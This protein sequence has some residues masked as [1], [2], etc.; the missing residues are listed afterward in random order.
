MRDVRIGATYL[1]EVPHEIRADRYP[2]LDTAPEAGALFG[3]RYALFP[4]RGCRFRL[5]VTEVDTDAARPM[6]QGLRLVDRSYVHVEL[7]TEQVAEFGLP[8]GRYTLQGTL[9]DADDK[10]VRLPDL[11]TLRV[12]VRWL[13][14][15]DAQRPP[16]T[17][18]D[19]D[20]QRW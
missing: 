7:T 5:T 19:A 3:W 17:H 8:P 4:L 15:G 14:P 11:T 12:P 20:T 18:R 10:P 16:H 6:V 1:V 9:T 13:Y 2:E